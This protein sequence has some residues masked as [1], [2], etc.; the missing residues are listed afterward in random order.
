[1]NRVGDRYDSCRSPICLKP[2]DKR[3]GFLAKRKKL[4]SISLRLKI[5]ENTK[6]AKSFVDGCVRFKK[7]S[8]FLHRSFRI[9]FCE[10]C[11]KSCR[12]EN[13]GAKFF[14]IQAGLIRFALRRTHF[15][16]SSSRSAD[17]ATGLK[18]YYY[19]IPE[20]SKW[21]QEERIV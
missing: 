1:M 3:I 2:L 21:V 8:P 18:L 5:T 14:M 15:F 4:P 11:G 13:I 12:N 9:F 10:K 19:Y 6:I 17:P 7:T 20:W 16:I